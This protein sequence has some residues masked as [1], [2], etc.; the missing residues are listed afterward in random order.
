M[1]DEKRIEAPNIIVRHRESTGRIVHSD[2]IDRYWKDKKTGESI[3][4]VSYRRVV[5]DVCGKQVIFRDATLGV[6][7]SMWLPEF[8]ARFESAG[9]MSDKF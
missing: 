8:L 1:S 9:N 6:Q 4:V 7:L 2:R 5:G 3:E